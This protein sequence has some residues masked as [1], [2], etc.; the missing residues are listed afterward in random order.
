MILFLRA[1]VPVL[2][3]SVVPLQEHRRI[4]TALHPAYA[5]D[6][7]FPEERRSDKSYPFG[8]FHDAH[9]NMGNHHFPC[10][11]WRVAVEQETD[12]T[13]VFVGPRYSSLVVAAILVLRAIPRPVSYT[14]LT[15]PT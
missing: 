2:S 10:F 7:L 8:R 1:L 3:A 13:E 6:A 12:S 4:G 15:L 14:H 9:E 11:D 5:V